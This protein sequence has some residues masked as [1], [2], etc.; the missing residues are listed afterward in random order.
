MIIIIVLVVLVI[1]GGIGIAL[2]VQYGGSD[3]D[4]TT[5]KAP[6]SFQKRMI[7]DTLLN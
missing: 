5:T 6:E 2:G 1:I 7:L 4:K 3:T